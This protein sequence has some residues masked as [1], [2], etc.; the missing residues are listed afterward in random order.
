MESLCGVNSLVS[1]H[2]PCWFTLAVC[3]TALRVASRSS[4]TLHLILALHQVHSVPC[5][6][7]DHVRVT[8]CDSY[9]RHSLAQ[10]TDRRHLA[11]WTPAVRV[12]EDTLLVNCNSSFCWCL[13]RA[14]CCCIPRTANTQF[15]EL[16]VPCAFAIKTPQTTRLY[17]SCWR[18]QENSSVRSSFPTKTPRINLTFN[19]GPPSSEWS[20]P[21]QTSPNGTTSPV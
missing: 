12:G 10:A 6:T 13:L 15:Q 9:K 4:L 5:Y 11:G 20:R 18:Q 7:K 19:F 17:C 14:P 3:G 1:T 16:Q 8:Q 21:K 2:S